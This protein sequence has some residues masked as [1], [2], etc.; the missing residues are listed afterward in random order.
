MA[1]TEP[2][3]ST[4]APGTIEPDLAV[5]PIEADSYRLVAEA[6]DLAAWTPGARA[7]VARVLHATADPVFAETL[8][9]S[10][11]AV[12]AGVAALRA[13]AALVTDVEMTRAGLATP[14]RARASCKLREAKAGPG[15]FPTASANAMIAAATEH[16]D[17]AIFVIGC[18]PTALVALLETV[19]SGQCRPALVVGLPVGFVGAA[20]AKQALAATSLP[21]LTNGGPRGGSAAAA[22]ATNALWR[23]AAGS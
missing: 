8:L 20:E 11:A 5:H 13:G 6:V 19:A 17:G 21:H 18:A 4:P 7:V 3:P 15:G 9:V 16:P 23:L 14:L 22:A 12:A 2:R 1:M 10:E